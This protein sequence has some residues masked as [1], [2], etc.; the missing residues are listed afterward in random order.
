MEIH[1][2]FHDWKDI[3]ELEEQAII[4]S[5]GDSADVLFVILSGEVELKLR[6]ESL[7][8]EQAGGII[9]EMAIIPAAVCNATAQA[10]TDVR[11]ARLD[12]RQLGEVVNQN[13]EFSLHVM[14]ILANRLRA[15]NRFIA[16]QKQG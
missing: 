4:Y 15:V 14:A 3:V 10:L 9:G 12:R 13:T 5:E 11:L 2:A 7:G 16:T 6:G 8:I 1:H